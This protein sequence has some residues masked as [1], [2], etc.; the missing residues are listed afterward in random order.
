[1]IDALQVLTTLASRPPDG[2]GASNISVSIGGIL[3]VIGMW[4]VFAKAGKPG[5]AAIIPIYNIYTVL[6]LIGK[7]WYWLL[8]MLIP[9]VNLVFLFIISFEL[10]EHFGKSKLF[11]V[12]LVLLAPIFYLILG[13]DESKY[14]A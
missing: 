3:A 7:P 11:G 8:F 4:K 5:W 9:L 1:M 10:A 2:G 13:F 14:R 12:G 6:L